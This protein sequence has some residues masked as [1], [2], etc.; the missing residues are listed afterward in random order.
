MLLGKAKDNLM[1]TNWG[2]LP[3]INRHGLVQSNHDLIS[4]VTMTVRTDG[5]KA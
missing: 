5:W 1:G 2:F 4:A 3:S